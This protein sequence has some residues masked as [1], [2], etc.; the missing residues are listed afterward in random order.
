GC[1]Q[2]QCVTAHSA[3]CSVRWTVA[4]WHHPRFSSAV[5]GVYDAVKP[6]WADLYA[7]GAEVVLNS[8]YEVYERFAPQT[9][10]GALDSQLGIREF[11][12][13]T[14]GIGTSA[15][16][17]V[18]PNSEVRN[19]VVYGVLRLTLGDG[20][21]SWNFIPVAGQTFTD[22]GSGTCHGSTAPPPAPSVNAGPDLTT[23]PGDTL[24]LT[25]TFSDAG[26]N[27]AP[28]SYTIT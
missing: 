27:D 14:G 3:A 2:E 28:W 20:T 7:A 22:A 18:Q 17:A 26:A 4:M 10:G 25:T 21:Y 9:P 24:K 8:H 15:I 6:F 16:A 12:V 23:H 1:A 19:P 13:G 11:T 5:T